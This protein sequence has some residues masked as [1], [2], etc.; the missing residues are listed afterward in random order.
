MFEATF[1]AAKALPYED[2]ISLSATEA[3]AGAAPDSAEVVGPW[4]E[5]TATEQEVARLASEGLSDAQIARRRV[6]SVRTV[7][8]HL[9]N[10]RRKLAV[11]SRQGISRWVPDRG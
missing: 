4:C 6:C 11:D 2:I 10:V 5:L 3:A 8:K 9:E 1:R 7:E